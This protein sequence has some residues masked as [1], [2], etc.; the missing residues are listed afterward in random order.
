[1]N[2]TVSSESPS[3]LHFFKYALRIFNE[4]RLPTESAQHAGKATNL[5][6]QSTM[7]AVVTTRGEMTDLFPSPC[8]V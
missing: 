7:L 1:M 8:V 5:M 3:C 4:A 2:R 6:I